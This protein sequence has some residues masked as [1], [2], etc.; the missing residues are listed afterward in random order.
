MSDERIS[1]SVAMPLRLAI[2]WRFFNPEYFP[3]K[4][5]CSISKPRL[6]GKE[7]S[8]PSRLFSIVI[9]PDEGKIN[10]DMPRSSIVFP[11]PF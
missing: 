7:I 10:P 5:G 4:E 1:D 3:M 11:E 6:L 2:N 9:D 8:L